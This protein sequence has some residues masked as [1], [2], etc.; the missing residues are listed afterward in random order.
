[1]IEL[2]ARLAGSMAVVIGLMWLSARLMKNRQV[3]GKGNLRLKSQAA[4]PKS[5]PV[6]VVARHSLGR[7][8]SVAVVR[9]GDKTL[10]LGVTETSVSLLTQ[11]DELAPVE[12]QVDIHGTDVDI[13]AALNAASNPAWTG[14]LSQVRER[15]VR[16]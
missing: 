1:M 14:L 4:K 3:P 2:L 16:R 5:N 7:H 12:D 13:E 15:T 11:L 6:E 9:T 8:S 10:V